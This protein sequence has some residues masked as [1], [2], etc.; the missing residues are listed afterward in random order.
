MNY[1]EVLTEQDAVALV[2]LLAETF[3]VKAPALRFN[4]R[5]RR[6]YYYPSKK[7]I[8]LSRSPKAKTVVHEFAHYLDHVETGRSSGRQANDREWHSQ[9]F[10]YKLRKIVLTCGGEYPWNMEYRQIAKWAAKDT[11]LTVPPK[12]AP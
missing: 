6:G 7:A 4:A 12:E 8:S 5:N 10:Y 1:M 9:G 11:A 3:K 2:Q